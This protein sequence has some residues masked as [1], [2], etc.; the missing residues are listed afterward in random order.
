MSAPIIANKYALLKK[1]A[2]GGMAEVFLAKQI[3]LDGFEKLV[4]LKRILPHLSE[5]EEFVRMFLDEARTAADLRHP[6]VVNV[7]E[8]GED[9]GTYFIAMEFLAGKDIRR[10][11]RRAER[12]GQDVPLQ[13]ALQI[14]IDTANGLH[15]AHQKADLRGNPLGIVHRDV[16]PQ[17]IIVTYDGTA[18]IVD[19]GIAKAASSTN[20]TASGVLKGKYAYMSP[21]QAAAHPIDHRTDLFALGVVAYELVT[22][23]RLFKRENEVGTLNA[24]IECK[25]PPPSDWAPHLPRELDEILL[26]ALSPRPERRFDTCQDFAFALEE[27]LS[28]QRLV[29]SQARVGQFMQ[30]IFRDVIA[31]EKEAD[32]SLEDSIPSILKTPSVSKWGSVTGKGPS[33]AKA[34]HSSVPNSDDV[35]ERMGAE[36][37]PGMG[38]LAEVDPQAKTALTRSVVNQTTTMPSAPDVTHMD[39]LLNSPRAKRVGSSIGI[40]VGGILVGLLAFFLQGD[41]IQKGD[42]LVKSSPE[43]ATVYVNGKEASQ[44]SPALVR[45]LDTAVIHEVTVSMPGFNTESR[46]VKFAEDQQR[47]TLQVQMS[48]EKKPV[49][50]T[51]KS[52]PTG[53]LVRDSAGTVLGKTPHRFETVFVGD[54]VSFYVEKPGHKKIT[55]KVTLDKDTVLNLTLETIAA[56]ADTESTAPTKKTVVK[57]KKGRLKVK[58]K[59]WAYIYLNGRKVGETP[60][61]PM[62]LAP[63]SYT[64]K[65][66]NPQLGKSVVK[67]IQIKSG[68][69][70]MIRE[71]W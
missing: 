52:T 3:G 70:L 54:D 33:F 5:D 36:G 43:G 58:V 32:Y 6:N 8:V 13:H 55:R 57:K 1:L 40:L 16:S 62:P 34:A 53:A 42:L 23:R 51:V 45:D 48:A 2:S 24:I 71:N 66:E 38:T 50:L 39:T 47:K 10:T 14:I 15:Y 26:K 29:H 17:N 27:F 30:K 9:E 21:E 12:I 44:P 60:I 22:M 69:D 28:E 67:K 65:L 68:Q 35:T 46:Q 64:V 20:H 4:V 18:K 63:G 37:V 61:Q 11:Q 49:Q 41:G 31:E 25:V 7:F 56:A 59:T 19:F